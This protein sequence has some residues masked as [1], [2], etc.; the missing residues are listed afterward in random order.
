MSNIEALK[1]HQGDSLRWAQANTVQG[2]FSGHASAAA[3]PARSSHWNCALAANPLA[4]GDQQIGHSVM[5][6]RTIDELEKLGRIKFPVKDTFLS[7]RFLAATD[8]M[9]FS[10][11]ENRIKTGTDIVVW[12]KHHW[13]ANYIISGKGEVT[14]LTSEEKWPLEPGVVCVVGPN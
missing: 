12:L 3:S 1:Q 8:G 5:F 2:M 4:S 13:E 9:G 7:A 11:N 6:I 10:Y 14:D